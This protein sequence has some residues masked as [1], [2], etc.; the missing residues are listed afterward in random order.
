VVAIYSHDE[1]EQVVGSD[2]KEVHARHKMRQRK[3]RSGG[4]DHDPERDGWI[5][6]D[7]AQIAKIGVEGA[8][9]VGK[10][11]HKAAVN[12]FDATGDGKLGLD[13]A[14][15]IGSAAIDTVGQGLSNARDA[16]GSGLSDMG[17]SISNAFSGW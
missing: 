5:E 12:T 2:R 14:R 15:A 16:I 8:K 11:I 3:G 9:V 10:E 17:N 13:D 1:L 6:R 4:F 7:A